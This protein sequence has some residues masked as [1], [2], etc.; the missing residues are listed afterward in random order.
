MAVA[1]RVKDDCMGTDMYH[2]RR[3]EE[4]R[5]ENMLLSWLLKSK[6]GNMDYAQLKE[7]AQ[8]RTN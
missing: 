3:E 4:D 8:H 5:E 6:E 7:L 2:G 1:E